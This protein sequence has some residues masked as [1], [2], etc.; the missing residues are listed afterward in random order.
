MADN[1][2]MELWNKVHKIDPRHTKP[3]TGKSFNGT[4]PSPMKMVEMAT[5]QWGP[6]GGKW[7]I[8]VISSDFVPG[9]PL[10]GK[11][12]N[13]IGHETHHVVR[14]E[15]WHPGGKFE[16][17]GQTVFSGQRKAGAF[18]GDED[19]A[20]KSQTDALTKG[21]SWLGFAAD[22]HMGRYDDVKY[23]E[24]VREEFVAKE[25]QEQA[26]ALRE[27]TL[28]ALEEAAAEGIASLEYAWK[29]ITKEERQVCAKDLPNL[30]KK[31]ETAT[32]PA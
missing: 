21:L 1:G 24:H 25:H 30:K 9:P 7:G 23:V 19:A 20:K 16:C 5:E 2:N 14:C 26:N 18:F 27:S 32:P 22:I 10:I 6:I 17:F 3:I 8:R 28:R 13:V 29:S 12:G 4:S 15:I 11:D 31:A